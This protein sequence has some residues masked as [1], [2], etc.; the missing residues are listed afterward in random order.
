MSKKRMKHKDRDSRPLISACVI[1]K[2]EEENLPTWLACV[3]QLADELVV[4]DTGSEDNTA[5]LAEKAGARVFLYPWRQDFA[6][7][8][9]YAMEQARGRWIVFLD[10]DEFFTAADCKRLRQEIVRCDSNAQVLG[11]LFRLVNIDRDQGDR[12]LSQGYQI[13][14]I[15]NLPTFRYHGAVHERLI[16]EDKT[17]PQGTVLQIEGITVYH[18]GYSTGVMTAKLHRNLEILLA[19]QSRRGPRVE[20]ASFLA[21]CYYGLGMF[22]ET[23]K[24]ARQSIEAGVQLGGRANRP[25]ALLVESLI[26]LGRPE[27]EIEAAVT[28]GERD[29]PGALEFRALLADYHFS[30][31]NYL[32]ARSEYLDVVQLHAEPGYAEKL[33]RQMLRDDVL[34][35]LPHIH[36]RLARI[37][38]WKGQVELALEEAVTALKANRYLDEALQVMLDC[39]K[40]QAAADVIE[41]LNALYDPVADAPFLVRQLRHSRIGEAALY[42]ERQHLKKGGASLLTDTERYLLAGHLSAAGAEAVYMQSACLALGYVLGL[43]DKIGG[44]RYPGMYQALH[45]GDTRGAEVQKLSRKLRN[46]R[47][48]LENRK[49]KN[50]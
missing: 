1:V 39:L 12:F 33:E 29:C 6:A 5:G 3:K 46:L 43:A 10:A 36:S 41:A 20:D 38:F 14:V 19:E 18:T 8:K 4:V 44:D 50:G 47:G 7:A 15:R 24:Y 21:D 26:R 2:N 49:E 28:M 9:N 16:N 13:R 35:M 45:S 32:R 34:G 23:A 31:G 42:Y 27:A 17:N 40:G 22:E 30:V 37:A 48:S 25:Y 11:M